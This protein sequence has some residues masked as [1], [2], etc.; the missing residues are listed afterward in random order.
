MSV[1]LFFDENVLYNAF[2]TMVNKYKGAGSM[3]YRKNRF[4]DRY[5]DL[6][7][8]KGGAVFLLAKVTN[9]FISND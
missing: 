4:H 6:Y 9:E 7:Y 5:H 3:T 1:T 8:K 2:V